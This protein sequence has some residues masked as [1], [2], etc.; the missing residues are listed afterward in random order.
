VTCS[1]A[2][3]AHQLDLSAPYQP[4]LAASYYDS[5]Q[6][7]QAAAY[8]PL[9]PATAAAVA[10]TTPDSSPLDLLPVCAI[11]DSTPPSHNAHS[12]GDQA[13]TS[14]IMDS[15]DP[16]DD[17]CVVCNVAT[18]KVGLVHGDEMC[19]CL[20]QRCAGCGLYGSGSA[21]PMCGQLVQEQLEIK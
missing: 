10:A 18:R 14:S 12:C 15:T 17:V 16:L 11:L 5:W 3:V 2:S 7:L 20:C 9:A 4:L 13:T 6:P 1:V 21:C 19:L 8:N